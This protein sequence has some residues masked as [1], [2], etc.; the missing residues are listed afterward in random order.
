MKGRFRV[1][2]NDHFEDKRNNKRS[3]IEHDRALIFEQIENMSIATMNQFEATGEW[4]FLLSNKVVFVSGGAGYLSQSIARTCYLH[5]AMVVLADINQQAAF[6]AKQR[7]ANQD[8]DD[9]IMVVEV[10]VRNENSI[11]QAVDLVVSKWNKID[12]LINT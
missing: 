11:K 5:G 6:E 2:Y 3:S 7:I 8:H 1:F 9:R 10:D 4:N 12:I